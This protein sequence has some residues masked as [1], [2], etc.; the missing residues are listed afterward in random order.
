MRSRCT[1]KS[2]LSVLLASLLLTQFVFAGEM[3][4]WTS[5]AGSTVEAEYVRSGAGNV[6]LKKADGA[7]ITI[8]LRSLSDA[9]QE[10]LEGLESQSS[11]DR[12]LGS[13]LIFL[14]IGQSNMSGRA[15]MQAEDRQPME[16]VMLL[17][18]DG[19]WE[20]AKHPLNIYS[21]DRK[22]PGQQRFGPA[23][24]FALALREAFPDK[25]V[26][27]IVN[28]RG[29]AKIEEWEKG[30][31]LYDN[32]MKRAKSVKDAEF[33]GVLWIQGFSNAADTQYVSKLAK[34]VEDLRKDL[35][36]PNLPVVIAQVPV[37]DPKYPINEQIAKA[38]ESIKNL[39][40]ATNE[41]TAKCDQY[42]YDRDSY[43]K[44]GNRMAD[45]YL[46]LIGMKK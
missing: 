11:A 10:Y 28:A 44:I 27:L 5:E 29:G 26:K 6:Y 8:S 40:A 24:P 16:G 39:V 31:K 19:E 13:E 45:K 18:A 36:D 37:Y 14:C 30:G 38:P 3:R 23:G 46:E 25:T 42:H 22:S 35:K 32:S 17:N 34:L 15:P 2:T 4:T 7:P 43:I 41:D 33:A 9:D 21:T 12:K 20:P 1:V